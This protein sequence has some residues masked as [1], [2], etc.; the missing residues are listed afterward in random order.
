MMAYRLSVAGSELLLI[1]VMDFISFAL[2]N[3]KNKA[4]FTDPD[5]TPSTTLIILFP[6][7]ESLKLTYKDAP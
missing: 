7:V 2:E 3:Q 5:Q 4:Y 6:H 1:I